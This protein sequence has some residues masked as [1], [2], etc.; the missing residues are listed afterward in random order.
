MGKTR[1]AGGFV[2]NI[3][4]MHFWMVGIGGAMGALC[5]FALSRI[6]RIIK[7]WQ[8]PLV[9]FFINSVGSLALGLLVG[10]KAQEMVLLLLGTGF[11]G[12]F[13]TFS[14]FNLESMELWHK[15]KY[16]IFFLYLILSYGICIPCAL[17]GI[18]LGNIL[19]S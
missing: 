1:E 9:T 10:W 12:G 8:F 3:M 6:A 4:G 2:G 15:K 18:L 19:N 7:N 13:T 5:R 11:L 14:T 17:V 16:K